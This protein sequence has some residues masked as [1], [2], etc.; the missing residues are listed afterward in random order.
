[1]VYRNGQWVEADDDVKLENGEVVDRDGDFFDATGRA[2]ENAWDD[3][4]AGVKE[5][6][7]DIEKAAQKAGDKVEGAVDDDHDKDK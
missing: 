3:T 7:K 5:A 6:G 1:M 4:K 2:I